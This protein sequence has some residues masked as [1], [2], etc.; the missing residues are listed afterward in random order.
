MNAN[1]IR[2]MMNKYNE[3]KIKWM[4][5]YGTEFGFDAWYTNQ[6]ITGD[7]INGIEPRGCPLPGNCACV[8]PAQIDMTVLY[9][10]ELARA[11]ALR[12]MLYDL[13]HHKDTRGHSL[14]G[15]TIK[16]LNENKLI[17][18]KP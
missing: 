6:V 12:N 15:A 14:Y 1:I 8:D 7:K 9:N 2:E 5:K 16:C 17:P 11:E 18:P 4:A 3:A 13:V 10:R